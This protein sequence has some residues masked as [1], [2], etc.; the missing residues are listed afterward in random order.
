M[1][2]PAVV[3][4]HPG[5]HTIFPMFCTFLP[6]AHDACEEPGVMNAV[7]MRTST[8]TLTG[9]F[10]LIIVSRTK[11]DRSDSGTAALRTLGPICE[12]NLYLLQ[13]ASRGSQVPCSA[14]AAD[15]SRGGFL[16]QGLCESRGAYADG[17]HGSGESDRGFEVKQGDIVV[18]QAQTCVVAWMCVLL[19]YFMIL[20]C[21][22][23]DVDVMFTCRERY[24]RWK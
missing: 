23:S 22:L 4:R 10:G 1:V 12:G 11:H 5:V 20:L 7:C 21:A 13:R 3:K 8:V 9:I 24:E 16:H 2:Y 15:R 18:V 19:L 6:P 17:P 14:P